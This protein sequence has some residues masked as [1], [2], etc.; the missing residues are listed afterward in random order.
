MEALTVDV[1]LTKGG[2]WAETINL[3]EDDGTTVKDTTGY[4][5]IMTITTPDGVVQTTLTTVA[6][7][8][9][10][11]T[12]AL[13]QF[14]LSLGYAAIQA[15]TWASAERRV[16]ITDAASIKTVLIIGNVSVR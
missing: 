7:A 2:D 4:S 1:T 9:I 16:I 15:Y 11:H 8:G 6:S 5:M 12:P 3:Y 14:N 10:V 13:G